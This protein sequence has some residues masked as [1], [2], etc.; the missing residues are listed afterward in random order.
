MN[1]FLQGFGRAVLIMLVILVP[2][3]AVFLLIQMLSKLPFIGLL[4]SLVSG[5]IATKLVAEPLIAKFRPGAMDPFQPSPEAY[6]QG[7]VWGCLFAI[8]LSC[9]G[10]WLLIENLL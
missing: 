5:A 3:L 4:L 10:F 9:F 1:S 2:T 8:G 6:S 7:F